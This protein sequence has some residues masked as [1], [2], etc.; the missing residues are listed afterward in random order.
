MKLRSHPL[1]SY[2]GLPNW[3]PAWTWIGGAEDKHPKGEVGVLLD[4]R[5]STIKQ[6]ARCFLTIE[7]DHAQYVGCLLFDDRS[8][9]YQIGTLLQHQFGSTLEFIGSLNL[10]K[11]L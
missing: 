11:P 7:H 2:N 5:V 1:M 4:V 3:P 9:C 10:S 8:F 6:P